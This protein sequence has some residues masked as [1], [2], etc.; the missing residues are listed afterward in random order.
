MRPLY[1]QPTVIP[2][3]AGIQRGGEVH[4]TKSGYGLS[5]HFTFH[6]VRFT[7]LPL[8]LQA[9]E[10]NVATFLERLL[11]ACETN[12]SLLCV[13]LDVDPAK[14]PIS[15]V[16][17][18]NSAIVDA[19]HDLVC[20][21]K[22]NIAF[23]ESRGSEGIREL[24]GTIAHI[25]DVA[26][27]VVLLLDSKRGDIGSTNAAYARAIF[28][29]WGADATTLNAYA[30]GADLGPFLQYEDKAVFVWCRS[31]NRGAAELQ[32]LPVQLDGETMPYYQAVARRASGW[33][34]NGTVG[35]VV[36]ATYPRELVEVR[37]I[38]PDAPILLPG[39]GAQE[40]MLRPS[41]EAGLDRMGRNLLVSSSRGVLYASS[42]P[43]TFAD[44]ARNAAESLRDEINAVLE[45]GGHSWS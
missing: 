7:L 28:E 3:K 39:V 12:R 9:Y 13:G 44:A 11:N 4:L 42:D 33:D 10:V 26:P 35:L 8:D 21:Y 38:A 24:E 17:A 43:N 37:A 27:S 29:T 32:D 45:D 34:A 2:A 25:R 36:G 19:T 40:G 1:T 6:V 30:G 41:V 15:D 20:A 23:Y 14:M 31:S 22:P 5:D 18:F 16:V